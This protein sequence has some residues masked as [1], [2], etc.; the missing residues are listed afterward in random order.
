[1]SAMNLKPGEL[2]ILRRGW[3]A[4]H[5]WLLLR[6]LSQMLILFL[7]L[8]GPLAGIWII[9]G[10]L[11]SSLLFDTIPMTDP[12]LFVQMIAAGFFDV[13]N[14]KRRDSVSKPCFRQ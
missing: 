14:T 13:Q 1:M 7:F 5:R 4:V 9:K 3:W 6:R 11:A 12:L 8:L 2:A 10:N